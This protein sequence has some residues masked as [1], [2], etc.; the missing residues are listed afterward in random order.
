VPACSGND[1]EKED[2][3]S[4]IRVGWLMAAAF[5]LLVYPAWAG[6]DPTKVVGPEK[7]AECHK[8][9][10]EAWKGTHHFDTVNTM[11]RSD[12]AQAIA[13]KLGLKSIK[14]DSVCLECHY[15]RQAQGDVIAGVSCESCHGAARDWL[16]IHNDFGGTGVTQESE[17]PDHRKRRIEQSIAKGM[18]RPDE[19]YALVVQCFACHNVP[20]EKL[21]NVGGHQPG[22][23]F[24][25]VSW[26]EGEVR[27]NYAS[28]H[29]N[30]EDS[31]ERRRVLYV[32]GQMVALETNLRDLAKATEKNTYAVQ[33]AKRAAAARDTLKKISDAVKV[34]EIDQTLAGNAGS[35]ELKL[36]NQAAL[37]KAADEAGAA[38][39]RFAATADGSRLAGVDPLLPPPSQYKGTPHP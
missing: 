21:V 30:R 24:E 35:V 6:P 29:G 36:N 28:G 10:V 23:V 16:N 1:I 14:R 13:E 22:S 17:S 5:M 15:T 20:E 33:M 37:A 34:P 11:H 27:H 39:R 32:V 2:P 4:V 7:C 12:R 8:A 18:H 38:A 26:L 19:P 9:E 31:P 25:L 3:M